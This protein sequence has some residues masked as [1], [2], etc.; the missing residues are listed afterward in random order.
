VTW[1]T[2]STPDP[3]NSPYIFTDTTASADSMLFYRVYYQ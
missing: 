1:K 2:I 3:T